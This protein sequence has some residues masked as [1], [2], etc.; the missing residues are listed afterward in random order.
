MKHCRDTHHGRVS[1]TADGLGL[2]FDPKKV[3]A[4]HLSG[5]GTCATDV[6]F[7]NPL[8]YHNRS[9][10]LDTFKEGLKVMLS[11]PKARTTIPEA[12]MLLIHGKIR[13]V[14]TE[15]GVA[16]PSVVNPEKWFP[17]VHLVDEE[18]VNKEVQRVMRD[19]RAK[20]KETG[21][22]ELW[23]KF[24]PWDYSEKTTGPDSKN[25]WIEKRSVWLRDHDEDKVSVHA[26]YVSA[27]KLPTS[28]D[29]DGLVLDDPARPFVR[30]RRRTTMT[31]T[32]LP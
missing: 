18:A 31:R 11:G 4:I 9:F 15:M 12:S 19:L 8:G 27:D 23:K 29:D 7:P 25:W 10:S 30:R 21:V 20:L 2:I 28:S 24:L 22:H 5:V 1:M 13:N 6:C 16:N 3:E 32:I 26:R 17:F 14:L